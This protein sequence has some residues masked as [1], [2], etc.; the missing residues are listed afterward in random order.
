MLKLSM[1]F[2][3]ASGD[4]PD[5]EAPAAAAECDTDGTLAPQPDRDFLAE[6]RPVVVRTVPQAGDQAVDPGLTELRVTFSKDMRDESW[7]WVQVNESQYPDSE[8]TPRY[9]DART[10]VLTV[11][12]EPNH[13][14]AVWLNYDPKYMGFADT[15]GNSAVPYQLTFRTAAE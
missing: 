15:H 5:S 12:L 10:N 14:Y 9:E 13:V 3:C 2:A 8:G 7:S 6:F 11:A 4:A 1:L